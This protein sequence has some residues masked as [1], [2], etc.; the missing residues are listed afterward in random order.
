VRASLDSTRSS[1]CPE[2]GSPGPDRM[3]LPPQTA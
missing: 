1:S 2:S 3:P